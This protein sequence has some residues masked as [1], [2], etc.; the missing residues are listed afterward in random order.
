MGAACCHPEGQ[1]SNVV[2]HPE[3]QSSNVVEVLP[4]PSWEETVEVPSRGLSQTLQ[5]QQPEGDDEEMLRRCSTLSAFATISFYECSADPD[6]NK[7]AR[8]MKQRTLEMA[9]SHECPSLNK[10]L[11]RG[12]S[13]L[14]GKPDFTGV[15][16]CIDTWNLDEFLQACG[17]GKLKRLAACKA[18]WP[19]WSM[20]HDFDMIYFVNHGPLGDVEEFIDLSGKEYISYDGRK[21]KMTNTASWEGTTLVIIRDGPLGIFREERSL[22]D[23]DTLLFKLTIQS[24]RKPGS[25]WGRTFTR[26]TQS[27][28]RK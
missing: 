12:S 26:E 7:V 19:W 23:N 13:L 21:Q 24:G 3:G 17:V 15:W 20:E 9:E 5:M 18:P 1:S 22:I 10:L 16:K 2:E 8:L 28:D 11:S 27:H 6:P 25:S 14:T 4:S